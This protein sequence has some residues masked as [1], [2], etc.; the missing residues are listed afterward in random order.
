MAEVG[1]PDFTLT[2]WCAWVVPTGTPRPIVDKLNAAMKAVS[3]DPAVQA[4]F[5]RTGAKCVWSTPEDAVRH[6]AQQR[7]FLRE[8]V[9]I[10]GAKAD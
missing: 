8:V 9:R 3:E 5:L 2:S 6:A 4:R 1:V 7:V 10:S